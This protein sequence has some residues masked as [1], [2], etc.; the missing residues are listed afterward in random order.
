MTITP[1]SPLLGELISIKAYLGAARDIVTSGFMP[2]MSAL[3]QR[4]S[5]VCA[6]IQAAE[7]DEQSRCL[8]ELASIL[9]SLDE[10]ESA[11]RHW[12]DAHKKAE[13]P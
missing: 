3:E 13:T 10:C 4:I 2:D 11:M 1:S 12:Q 8:P 6:G 7:Q 9:K 5:D